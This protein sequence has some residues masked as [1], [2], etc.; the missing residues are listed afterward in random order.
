MAPSAGVLAAEGWQSFSLPHQV[1]YYRDP[2]IKEQVEAFAQSNEQFLTSLRSTFPNSKEVDLVESYVFTDWT[3]ALEG[4]LQLPESTVWNVFEEGVFER[5]TEQSL[6]FRRAVANSVDFLHNGALNLLRMR[7]RGQN[8]HDSALLLL[9]V[10]QLDPPEMMMYRPTS[11]MALATFTSF[12]TYL[13]DTEGP[14]KLQT[15][16][17]SLNDAN[18]FFIDRGG[19]E[20]RNTHLFPQTIAALYG[21]PLEDLSAEWRKALESMGPPSVPLDP[22]RYSEAMQYVNVVGLRFYQWQDL[23]NFPALMRD[24]AQLFYYF[25]RLDLARSEPLIQQIELEQAEGLWEAGRTTRGI[26]WGAA[27]VG[28]LLLGAI[29]WLLY[30]DYQRRQKI[31]Q[32][33]ATHPTDQKGF[34]LFLEEQLGKPRGRPNEPDPRD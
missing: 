26:V 33:L 18:Y 15:L 23:Y 28:L 7:Q 4:N 9:Q 22:V 34:D 1:L 32:F 2:A 31:R 29:A 5:Y 3:S 19:G 12:L 10:K 24:M 27:G 14:E 21:R 20:G 6:L 25:D 8:P 16:L 17:S 13:L 30:R 11:Q